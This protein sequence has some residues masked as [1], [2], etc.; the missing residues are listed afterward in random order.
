MSICCCIDGK[1][2]PEDR[3]RRKGMVSVTC[4]DECYAALRKAKRGQIQT[5]RVSLEE[6]ETLRMIRRAGVNREQL[7]SLLPKGRPGRKPRQ[8]A[9]EA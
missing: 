7:A 9:V 4:S 3:G 8:E 1:E 5:R 6:Y 2:V